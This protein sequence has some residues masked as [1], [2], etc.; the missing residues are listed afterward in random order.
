MTGWLDQT[1]DV[2]ALVI[3][4]SALGAISTKFLNRR[5]DNATAEQILAEAATTAAEGTK[6][7]VEVIR[8]LLQEYRLEDQKKTE[9][10]ITLRAELSLVNERLDKVEE[11][12]RHMLTRAAVHEAW[13]QMAFKILSEIDP[14][15]PEPPPLTLPQGPIIEQRKPEEDG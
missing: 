8:S 6:T 9:S 13:D 10:I 7:E 1:Y 12:E 14:L 15:H 2:V 5:V 4:G 11:R 3:G